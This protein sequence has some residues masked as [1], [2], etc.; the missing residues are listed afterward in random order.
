[1][2]ATTPSLPLRIVRWFWVP[3]EDTGEPR[4]PE[5][6]RAARAA[7][8]LLL[9]GEHALGMGDV[10]D[11]PLDAPSA[12]VA[13]LVN[14]REALRVG[15]PAALGADVTVT[16]LFDAHPAAARD[17]A[18]DA[19]ELGACRR[20]VLDASIETLA[21]QEDTALEAD[22]IRA[23]DFTRRALD[24]AISREASRS[25]R[26]RARFTRLSVLALSL[27][28]LAL[29]APPARRAFRRDLGPDATWRASTTMGPLPQTGRGFHPRE[30]EGNFFFQTQIEAE[31]WIEFDLGAERRIE[32]VTVQN[33]LDCC[34]D[35][36][37][38]LV[39]EVGDGA[40]RWREVG[41][42]VE[43]FY[44]YT[45]LFPAAP[46]RYVRLRVPR[47]TS[48]HLGGVQIK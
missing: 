38:P 36:S 10:G 32:M 35:W 44:F 24:A 39:I 15:L 30:G 18:G 48:L 11:G 3:L 23:R 4:P 13:A 34:Q 40:R 19:S 22:A 29:L 28:A 37:V 7:R 33:R 17:A 1:M 2:S 25:E 31:P 47:Q 21:A 27:V 20:V 42:R 45:A 8:A 5:A 12:R 46:A 6:R 16:A 14:F 9:L 43:P 26:L 41:R